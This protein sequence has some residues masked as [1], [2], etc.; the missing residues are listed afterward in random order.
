LG[1]W[2]VLWITA[3]PDASAKSVA[4][5][6]SITPQAQT[7]PV[8]EQLTVPSSL[9]S[10][11][12]VSWL[13]DAA[14][15]HDALAAQLLELELR[16]N[17]LVTSVEKLAKA[18][19]APPLSTPSASTAVVQQAAAV[20]PA[21]DMQP[22]MDVGL[23]PLQ[24]DD[25]THRQADLEMQRLYLREQAAR[26]G[27]IGTER[28]AEALSDLDSVRQT[29]RQEVGEHVY[30]R[31]LYASGQPNRIRVSS[32]IRGSPAEQAG[33]LADDVIVS[34]GG[35]TILS[36]NDLTRAISDGDPGESVR[37]GIVRDQYNMAVAMPRGPLGVRLASVRLEPQ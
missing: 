28:Y 12:V 3:D 2:G 26:E 18:D 7:S 14:A 37:V 33:L 6:P 22:Y 15:E 30:D 8:R 20:A 19:S 13:E 36:Y 5:Q 9:R 21:N 1:A 16:L 34:Y 25:I 4:V 29:I 17:R 24:V 35:Q 27:W 10:A 11:G 32:I 31:Y 23:D